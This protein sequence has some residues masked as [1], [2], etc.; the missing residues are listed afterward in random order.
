MQDRL[1]TRTE[2]A[3]GLGISGERVRQLASKPD[4]PRPVGRVG[5]ALAWHHADIVDWARRKGRT[6]ADR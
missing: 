3:R 6:L 5:Q 2:I 1:I 4:F